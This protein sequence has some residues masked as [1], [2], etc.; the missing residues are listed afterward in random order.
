MAHT[1]NSALRRRRCRG[2]GGEVLGGVEVVGVPKTPSVTPL[3]PEGSLP[4]AV[5]RLGGRLAETARRDWPVA[6]IGDVVADLLP[7]VC[8]LKLTWQGWRGGVVPML[9]A[10]RLDEGRAM[11][12]APVAAAA[13]CAAEIFGLYAKDVDLAG[14]RPAGISLWRMGADWTTEDPNEPPLAFLP[15]R[16]WIVGLGN[17][18]QAFA[19]LLGCLPFAEPSKVEIVLQ[20]YDRL[21]VSNLSTSLLSFEDTIGERKARVVAGWL[22]ERG[23]ETFVLER[24]FG[25]KTRRLDGDPAVALCGVDNAA[26]R[27]ALGAPDF[28]LVIEAGLGAGPNGFR[29]V[30]MHTFP[31]S[32]KP[33]EIWSKFTGGRNESFETMAAYRDLKRKGMDD[34]GLAQLASRTVGV[35][36]VGL[37]AGCIA[38]S[39]LLR[40]LNGGGA[41]EFASGSVAALDDVETGAIDAAPYAFGH[42]P[43]AG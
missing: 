37:I 10:V 11:A 14:R 13:I 22:D 17:L 41:L 4:E 15:C 27:M 28:E 8:A 32:R 5:V 40:R 6:V 30:A 34:C 1:T 36:F 26:A 29:S 42:V 25:A 16:L 9:A 31:A 21:T 12:L 38:V 7:S 3:A 18:G 2:H 39:E 43:A 33:E 20:D 23:F 19:W 35:P 24:P